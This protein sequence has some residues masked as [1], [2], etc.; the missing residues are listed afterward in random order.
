MTTGTSEDKSIWCARLLTSRPEEVY[1]GLKDYGDQHKRD[2]P[3]CNQA[4]ETALLQRDDPLIDLGLAQ[5]ANTTGV[6]SAVF[7]KGLAAPTPMRDT[8]YLD[9]LRIACLSNQVATNMLRRSFDPVE[10]IGEAEF[11]RVL[12]EAENEAHALFCNPNLDT[13]LLESLYRRTGHFADLSEVNWLRLIAR[14]KNNPRLNDRRD[15]MSGPDLG[16][17]RLHDAVYALLETAP[18]TEP[19]AEILYDLLYGLDPSLVAR[20]ERIDHVLT[21]WSAVENCD[22]ADDRL[23]RGNLA[24]LSFI[25]KFCCLIAALYGHKMLAPKEANQSRFRLWFGRKSGVESVMH[26]HGN[27]AVAR[28]VRSAYYAKAQLTSRD[29]DYAIYHADWH[30]FDFAVLFNEDVYRNPTLRKLLEESGSFDEERYFQRCVQIHHG[31]PHFDPRPLSPELAFQFE[32][33]RGKQPFDQPRFTQMSD[34][35]EKRLRRLHA[36]ADVIL[37]IVSA[38]TI[39]FGA[40]RLAALWAKAG[41]EYWQAHLLAFAAMFIGVGVLARY[42][43]RHSN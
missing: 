30:V 3:E 14:S 36:T 9:G 11:R 40:D 43:W 2:W 5:F 4:L 35:I 34:E 27:D 10:I 15:S 21:R 16:H 25:Q 17:Y 33:W 1:R 22:L 18:T 19:W 37:A 41:L 32:L 24:P 42:V 20:P 26:S 29:F 38:A 8:L 23:E 31:S 7:K 13:S 6:V 39:W 28:A 12:A